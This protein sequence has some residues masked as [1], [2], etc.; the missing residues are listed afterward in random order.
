MKI[1][2]KEIAIF[3]VISAIMYISKLLMQGLPNIHLLGVIIVST[4][5]IFSKKAVY[6]IYG[7]VFLEGIFGGFS[8]WWIPYLYIW[9]LLYFVILLEM[10][11][12]RKTSFKIQII[13]FSITCAIHGL[14]FGILYTPIWALITGMNAKTTLAWI[15]SGFIFDVYHGIGNLILCLLLIYP[16]TQGMKK[17]LKL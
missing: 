11:I 3:A 8:A 2:V 7:Y 12:F 5:I 10:K 14:L 1:S 13:I 6:P 4:T 9:T 15:A 16:I 17:A